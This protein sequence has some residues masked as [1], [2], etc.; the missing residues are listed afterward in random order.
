MGDGLPER[1]SPPPAHEAGSPRGGVATTYSDKDG[2]RVTEQAT[3]PEFIYGRKR[4]V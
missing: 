1:L 4:K 3:Y 2:A